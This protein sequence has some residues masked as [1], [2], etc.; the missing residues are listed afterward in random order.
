M[1]TSSPKNDALIEST[2]ACLEVKP[3]KDDAPSKSGK[4]FA[5][6]EHFYTQKMIGG[7]T[8]KRNQNAS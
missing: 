5:I 7:Q 3:A 6:F 4:Y 8:A 1:P 2:E